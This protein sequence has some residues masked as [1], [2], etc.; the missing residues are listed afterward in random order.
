[1]CHPA[2]SEASAKKENKGER[3]GNDVESYPDMHGA[4]RHQH[5][6]EPVKAKIIKTD[7]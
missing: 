7:D 3:G 2:P 5:Q 4:E 6:A 1:M